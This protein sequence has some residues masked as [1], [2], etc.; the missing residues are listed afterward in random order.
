MAV[1]LPGA[2]SGEPQPRAWAPNPMAVEVPVDEYGEAVQLPLGAAVDPAVLDLDAIERELDEI[3]QA[4][5]TV[6]T[7]S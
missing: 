3:D 2:S 1:E 7:A 5:R 4:L 6:A